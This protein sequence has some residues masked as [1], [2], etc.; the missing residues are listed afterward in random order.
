M[1]KQTVHGNCFICG[2]T[3]TE[4]A[5]KNHVIKEHNDGDEKCYLIKAEGAHNKDYWLF[6]TVPLEARLEAVDKFLRQIWCECCGHL[7]AFRIDR[8]EFAKSRQISVLTVGDKLLYEYDFGSTTEIMLTI[9]SEISRPKQ[10]QKVRLLARNEPLLHVCSTCGVPAT[11]MSSP[12]DNEF[13]CDAC[14]KKVEDEGYLL[15]IVN[16]PRSGECG[17]GGEEDKWTFDRQSFLV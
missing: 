12:W 15:P 14:V 11:L 1:P 3:S 17:Y 7:S 6:F 8:N 5:M 9:V 16:S 10:R 4:I 2:K 13:F